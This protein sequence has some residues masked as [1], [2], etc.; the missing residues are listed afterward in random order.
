MSDLTL[1][2][3]TVR[4]L[5]AFGDAALQAGNPDMAAQLYRTA[6]RDAGAVPPASY[7]SRLGMAQTANRRTLSTLE[8]LQALQ[9]IDPNVF[10][11]DGLATWLKTTPFGSDA[12][13]MQ[14]ADKHAHLLPLANWHWNLQTVVWAVQQARS[15]KGEFV[16][17][18]VFKGHT[19]LFTAEYLGFETWDKTWSLYDTFEGIPADQIDPGWEQGNKAAYGG[20]F[21]YE[22][23]RDRFAPFA[24]IK[25]IKGR[26][27]DVLAEDCPEAISFIHMDLNNTIAEIQALD[28]LY[29]RLT[30]GGVIVF[31]DYGWAVAYRQKAAEDQWFAARGLKI[32]QLPTGQGLFI[33][34]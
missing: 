30:P 33:K 13:F 18:G 32:L 1:K 14:L 27:P 8:A 28:A 9:K 5:V 3:M 12:R 21:S 17:L 23:V 26:V 29:D 10:I 2:N 31:D 11:G 19:T 34:P 6:I 7:T 20:T 15:V 22:E 25:V 4:Q 16:E 24:N